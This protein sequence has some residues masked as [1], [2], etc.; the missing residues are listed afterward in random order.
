[1]SAGCHHLL[2]VLVLSGVV[3]PGR[4]NSPATES[5]TIAKFFVSNV[6]QCRRHCWYRKSC[7]RF[8]HR[9]DYTRSSGEDNCVLHSS[10][11]VPVQSYP[12]WTSQDVSHSDSLVRSLLFLLLRSC[13]TSTDTIRT[14]RDE[15][16]GMSTLTFT[17][18]L[19]SGKRPNASSLKTN[20]YTVTWC[21]TPSQPVRSYQGERLKRTDG[22]TC[23]N[24]S[25]VLCVSL[26]G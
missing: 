24:D 5:A 10:T 25:L 18:L 2:T 19:S 1:M 9:K 3:L 12:Q 8:W 4:G 14:I 23:T 20:K 13:F 21:F 11:A 26:T 17:L 15:E 16:S 22:K 6:E 7:W